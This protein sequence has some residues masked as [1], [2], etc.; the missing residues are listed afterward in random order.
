MKYYIAFLIERFR[1]SFWYYFF[2]LLC[3][4]KSN[5]P[6]GFVIVFIIILIQKNSMN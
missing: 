5:V 6:I 3:D 1:K 4:K 2:T